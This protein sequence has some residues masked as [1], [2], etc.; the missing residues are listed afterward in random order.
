MVEVESEGVV[1]VVDQR[2]LEL[3]R[4]QR[5]F[6]HQLATVMRIVSGDESLPTPEH[7][8]LGIWIKT[9]MT[10]PSA[11]KQ[12]LAWESVAACGV[13]AGD[14]GTNLFG[15]ARTY[16]LVGVKQQHP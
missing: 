8:Q 12:I 13:R 5:R 6:C 11:E 14:G 4:L 15:Q 9:A 10:N 2:V 1:G 7:S 16:L 3:L